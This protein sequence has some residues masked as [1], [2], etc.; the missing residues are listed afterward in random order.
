MNALISRLVP[1]AVVL[2]SALFL[3]VKLA[4]PGDDPKQMNLYELSKIPVMDAGRV[5]PIDTMA[6]TTMLTISK[7]QTFKEGDKSGQP[8]IKWLMDVMTSRFAEKTSAEKYEVFKI[9]NDQL[10][11]ALGLKYKP[12]FWRY[13]INELG[14]KFGMIEDQAKQASEIPD[15]Q[16]DTYNQAVLE[17]YHNLVTFI[18]ISTLEEPEAIPATGSGEQWSNL[19]APSPRCAKAV[20]RIP[21]RSSF[22]RSSAL[23][24]ITS[25]NILTR[26]SRTIGN[27]STRRVRIKR[28][29]PPLKCSSITSSRS[30]TLCGCTSSPLS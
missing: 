8:A 10:V 18:R 27:T 4:P 14:G 20:P 16:R 6:R 12:E 19:R 13:S 29:G 9:Q 15:K 26:P 21:Q 11:Q 2:V 7:R 28:S 22:W 25:Q 24:P 3:L 23:T 17:L 5:K 30:T 1:A